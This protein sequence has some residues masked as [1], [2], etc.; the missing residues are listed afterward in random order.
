MEKKKKVII[1]LS[2]GV[3]SSVAAYL[4]L[5]QGYDVEGVFMRNWDSATNFDIHGNPTVFDEVCEQERDY[6]D[7]YLVSQKLGIKLHR[8][9]FIDDYWDRV[10]TYFLDE[11][12]KNRTPNPD[13]LC[14]NEIKFKAFVDYAK[15]FN[16]DYIAMGHYAQIDH[17][18][19][20][21]ILKR[22]K[23]L[24]K[25]QTYFLSQLQTEQLKDVIFPIGDLET[26]QVR[27]LA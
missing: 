7:A 9:D 6:Q 24:N 20:K 18:T 1:G 26:K 27:E 13:I 11:Y 22:A 8:V 2:G 16:Y 21:P 23:D 3:D 4:L 19:G 5:K 15:R 25:D 12:K 14:N 10:F 17:S